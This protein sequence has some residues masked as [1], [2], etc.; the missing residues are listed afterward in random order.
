MA[1]IQ[2]ILDIK[3]LAISSPE[4]DVIADYNYEQIAD[5]I[6]TWELTEDNNDVTIQLQNS[7]GEDVAEQHYLRV[8]VCDT[9]GF[10]AAT[11]VEFTVTTGT[12]VETHTA[13]KDLTIQSD[14]NGVIVL[15]MISTA[16]T[17]THIPPTSTSAGTTTEEPVVGTLRIGPPVVGARIGD[18]S[19]TLTLS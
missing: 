10:V 11:D 19:N 8:R 16:T 9:E 7:L 5:Y 2:Q 15:Q 17:T 12:T 1:R 14:A 3:E 13:G 4:W 6:S 18:Y